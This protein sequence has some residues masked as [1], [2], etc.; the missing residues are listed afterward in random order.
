MKLI[1]HVETKQF[2]G[3]LLEDQWTHLRLDRDLLKICQP[4]IGRN[5][6]VITAKEHLVLEKRIGILDKLRRE[7]LG[8]PTGEVDVYL[9]LVQA[10]RESVVFPGEG[11]MSHDNWH[12]RKVDR[13]IIQV[14]RIRVLE[15]HATSTTHTGAD[16]SLTG[17]KYGWQTGLSDHLVEDIRAPVIRIEFLHGGVKFETLHPEMLDQAARLAC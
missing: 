15:A 6:R 13:N 4:P 1:S 11:G 10:Y 17:V 9:R 14:H 2:D 7:V 12:I 16:S 3:I 5:H 8:G